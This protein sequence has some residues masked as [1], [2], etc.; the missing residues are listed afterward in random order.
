MRKAVSAGICALALTLG[1]PAQ[2]AET[3]LPTAA[4][5]EAA[6]QILMR[7]AGAYQ[8]EDYDIQWQLTDPR[9]RRWWNK[10]RWRQA[11][12]KARQRDGG[13]MSY[14]IEAAAPVYAAKLPCAEMGHCYRRGCRTFS[15]SSRAHTRRRLPLSRSMSRWRSQTRGGDLAAVH[16]PI[17]RWAKRPSF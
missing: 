14:T 12:T 6:T 13:L 2:A 1:A 8:A 4:D 10:A 7:W 16:S 11:M 3:T 9:Q 15:S 5:V 17:D